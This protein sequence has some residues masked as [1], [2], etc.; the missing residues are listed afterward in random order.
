LE[1]NPVCA[2][3]NLATDYYNYRYTILENFTSFSQTI[4][5]LEDVINS[6]VVGFCRIIFPYFLCNYAFV[7]CDLTTG[8][9]RPI[10]T[11]SCY[12]MR[13]LCFE[14][15]KHAVDYANVIDYPLVDDCENTLAN[16]Q[17]GFGFPCSSSSFKDNCIDI[18]GMSLQNLLATY[19]TI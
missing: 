1:K 16:L 4:E 13:T 9:P 7:P 11:D 3:F 19:T 12:F 17:K 2:Q 8:A 10:C 15:F 18:Q 5:A 14:D 6:G